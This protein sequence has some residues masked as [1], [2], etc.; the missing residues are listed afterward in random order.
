MTTQ[1]TII[2]A[3]MDAFYASVEQRDNPELRG[4]PVIV[5]SHPHAV[6]L[7]LPGNP[8]SALACCCLF[9]WPIVKKLQGMC[10]ELQW[11]TVPLT[12]AVQ[13]HPTRP[14]FRPC[15]LVGWEVSVPSWQGSG[16][17][18]HTSATHGLVQLPPCTTELCAGTHV[19][20]IPWPWCYRNPTS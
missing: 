8:V 17:L 6:V 3:D 4:K 1:P 19:E 5:G 9:G 14:A 12:S 10:P 18:A 7:G 11:H 20:C 13:P 2:H 15:M 16:D